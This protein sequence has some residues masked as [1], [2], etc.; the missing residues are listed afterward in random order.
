[1]VNGEINLR[2]LGDTVEGRSPIVEPTRLNT[3]RRFHLKKFQKL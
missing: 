1:M 2:V 3:L